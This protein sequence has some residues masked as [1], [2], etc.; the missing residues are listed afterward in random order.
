MLGKEKYS[1]LVKQTALPSL[2]PAMRSRMYLNEIK[3][4]WTNFI[5]RSYTMDFKYP[6]IAFG[7]KLDRLMEGVETIDIRLRSVR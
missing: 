3:I 1:R 2:I 6:G 4:N 5:D 7:V